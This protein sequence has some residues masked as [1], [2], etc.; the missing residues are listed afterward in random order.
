MQRD[1]VAELLILAEQT[2]EL[3]SLPVLGLSG[4]I[5]EGWSHLLTGYPRSGKTE[6]A[7]QL[8]LSWLSDRQVLYLSEESRLLWKERF[9]RLKRS[10]LLTTLSLKGQSSW[11]ERFTVVYGLGETV[12]SLM[13]EAFDGPEEVVIVDTIRSLLDIEDENNNAE[14]G[15]RLSPWVVAARDAGK[16]IIFLHHNRKGGGEYG[17]GIAG[18]HALLGVCDMA[19]EILRHPKQPARRRVVPHGRIVSSPEFL[20]E[21]DRSGVFTQLGN[22]EDLELNEVMTRIQALLDSGWMKTK[23]I[24]DSL[25]NP[26]PSDEQLR[27]ALNGLAASG[28]LQRDPPWGQ[29]AARRTVRWRMMIEDTEDEACP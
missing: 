6:L 7:V 8:A 16:T 20:Y 1:T 10:G 17:E 2:T 28:I 12:A 19:L 27:R 13:T 11:E 18:G 9:R 15:R 21:M 29:D 3:A 24:S 5:F 26:K 22:P 25:D 4:Y 14:V 23:E